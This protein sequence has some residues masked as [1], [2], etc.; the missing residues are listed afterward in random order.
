MKWTLDDESKVCKF[1]LKNKHKRIKR[2]EELMVELGHKFSLSSVKMKLQNYEYLDTGSGLANYSWMSKYTY[3]LQTGK[4]SKK[5]LSKAAKGKSTSDVAND[6]IRFV[7]STISVYLGEVSADNMEE[8]ARF[9]DYKCPYTGRDLMQEIMDKRAG[10]HAPNIVLD[11]IVP[12]ADQYGLNV[13]GNLI[14][15][16]KEANSRK[17]DD[18]FE[19]FI[20]NDKEIAKGASPEE[21]EARI[22][23][24]KAFQQ[25]IGCDYDPVAV[26]AAISPMMKDLYRSTQKY[27]VEWAGKIIRELEKQSSKKPAKAAGV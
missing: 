3:R 17:G 11:H 5:G 23:K 2:I 21:R 13:K 26:A 14:W 8:A 20:R 15:V 19:D 27:L 22:S 6:A 1:Y 24:I 4:K 18:S 12:T 10:K 9:F 16:D 25:E 7:L